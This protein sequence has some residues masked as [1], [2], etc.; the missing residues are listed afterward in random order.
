MTRIVLH[1][2]GMTC[3]HCVQT[4]TQALKGLVG[5]SRV[6]VNL[7]KKEAAVDYDAGKISPAE[8]SAKI[9]A[10]GYEVVKS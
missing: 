5:V 10:V 7:D 6:E 3:G 1:V 8:L 4:V 9:T 2:E